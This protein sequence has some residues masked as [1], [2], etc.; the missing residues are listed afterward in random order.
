M[1][2]PGWNITGIMDR[3][4]K[5][6]KKVSKNI[7]NQLTLADFSTFYYNFLADHKKCGPNCLH[8]KRFNRAIGYKP[9][10]QKTELKFK[11]LMIN[12]LPMMKKQISKSRSHLPKF[13]LFDR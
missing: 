5:Q 11:N 2:V 10:K 8:I 3:K 1:K 7:K 4:D 9:P 6:Q 13:N 12:K